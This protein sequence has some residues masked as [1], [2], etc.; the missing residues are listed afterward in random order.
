MYPTALSQVVEATVKLALG[1]GLSMW[2]YSTGINSFEATGMV[3]GQKCANYE[4]AKLVVL[5]YAAAASIAGVAFGAFCSAASI[6]IRHKL[7]GDKITKAE[8]LAP[9]DVS[10]T[11]T[12]VKRIVTIA[13]PIALGSCVGQLTG[14]ID[15]FT[16]MRRLHSAVD[17]NA[18]AIINMYGSAIPAGKLLEDIPNY[19]NGCYKGMAVTLYNLI[20]TFTV[21]M[22]ISALPPV[23]VAWTTRNVPALKRNVESVLRVTMLLVL[24]AGLSMAALSEN[25]LMLLYGARPNEVAVAAPLLAILGIA[26]IFAATCSPINSML[27]ATGHAYLPLKIMAGCSVVKIVLNYVMVAIPEINIRGAALST[28]VCYILIMT[29]SVFFLLRVTDI[30]P[31]FVSI[32]IKPLIAALLCA[33]SAFFACRGLDI[34]LPGKIATIAGIGVGVVVYLVSLVLIRAISEEDIAMLPHGD[35]LVNF[36]RKLPGIKTK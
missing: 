15:L 13:I 30:R 17:S 8:M 4:A 23:T 21:A 7:V 2:V 27:Q 24:P 11:R 33:A 10:S 1:L 28:L 16:V 19:L 14:V 6:F 3:F 34:F 9:Q 32:F 5:Q 22:G 29:I 26:V 25:I 18:A 12:I 35:K 31:N 36:Y 20:P